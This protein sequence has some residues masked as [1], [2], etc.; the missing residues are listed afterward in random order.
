MFSSFFVRSYIKRA[1]EDMKDFNN[2]KP[3]CYRAIYY[4]MI[5]IEEI[6]RE[7]FK[8]SMNRHNVAK[9]LQAYREVDDL[10]NFWKDASIKTSRYERYNYKVIIEALVFS[11][12]SECITGML[13]G[14]KNDNRYKNFAVGKQLTTYGDSVALVLD[15]LREA[16]KQS[17]L[18]IE[19]IKPND[20]VSEYEAKEI[21]MQVRV[22]IAYCFLSYWFSNRYSSRI[23]R[24]EFY[25]AWDLFK[26]YV[27]AGDI[28]EDK[29]SFF[30]RFQR[31]RSWEHVCLGPVAKDIN[32]KNGATLSS[33][34][35]TLDS[36]LRMTND[37]G[38]R[39]L[40]CWMEL[41]LT[42]ENGSG[43]I[44]SEARC[45]LRKELKIDMDNV[46]DDLWLV[47]FVYLQSVGKSS[48]G[49]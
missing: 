32:S 12:M 3:I 1:P 8:M 44:S 6:L 5:D 20:K 30:N 37:E 29:F 48:K 16:L 34:I 19:N 25:D 27:L 18:D 13:R 42:F 35:Y 28:R 11:I 39:R 31:K 40:Q 38:R 21:E 24:V 49:A 23:A 4:R 15:Q 26:R 22:T 47:A 41:I 45:V 2:N 9:L 17:D 36:F 10:E 33:S 43:F 7:D 14:G 46:I